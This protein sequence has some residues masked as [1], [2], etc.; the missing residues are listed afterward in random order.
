VP[1]RQLHGLAGCTDAHSSRAGN[2]LKL[3]PSSPGAQPWQIPQDGR[4]SCCSIERRANGMEAMSRK[5]FTGSAANN[6]CLGTSARSQKVLGNAFGSG[7]RSTQ[8]V[9]ECHNPFVSSKLF[10]SFTEAHRSRLMPA[11]ESLD[12]GMSAPATCRPKLLELAL[13]ICPSAFAATSISPFSASITN[14]L[15]DRSQRRP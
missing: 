9:S 5:F 14:A 15:R 11:S 7:W 2:I 4:R 1:T 8:K 13:V 6:R 3:P 12:I 10:E